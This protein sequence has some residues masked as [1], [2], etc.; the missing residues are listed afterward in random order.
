MEKKSLIIKTLK[1]TK[2]ANVVTAPA[3]SGVTSTRKTRLKK[4]ARFSQG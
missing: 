1:A 4:Y 3:K 2:K